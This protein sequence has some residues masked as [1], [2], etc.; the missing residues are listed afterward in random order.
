M[1]RAGASGYILKNT[2]VDDLESV[3][4]TVHEGN[5]VIS[6]DLMQNLLVSSARKPSPQNFNLSPRE[7]EILKLIGSGMSYAQIADY[8]VISISTVKFH[9]GNLLS[10]LGV[11]TRN[12]AIAIAAKN[13]LI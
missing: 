11:E 2:S 10:K 6:S 7:H 4:R 12:E 8:L 9:I 3:I 13:N 5:T 1:L